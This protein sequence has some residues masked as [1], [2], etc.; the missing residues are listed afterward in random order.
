PRWPPRFH[1]QGCP[2]LREK[3]RSGRPPKITPAVEQLLYA[4]A[5]L[6][7]RALGSHRPTWTTANLARWVQRQVGVRV[8]PK[9]IRRHLRQLNFVCRRPT[10]TV[11]HL[12]RQQPGYAQQKG[13]ITRLWRGP[14]GGP[15]SE[16]RAG[17]E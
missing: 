2:G 3:P 9:C 1:T 17:P 7:P 5:Q 6:S 12:A 4:W 15:E 8:T 13:A 16:W 10:W 11:K 14:P